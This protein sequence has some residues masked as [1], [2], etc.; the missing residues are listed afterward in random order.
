MIK[1]SLF[2]KFT[3]L[4]MLLKVNW[5]SPFWKNGTVQIHRF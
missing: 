3:S 4:N 5:Y 2:T 1:H